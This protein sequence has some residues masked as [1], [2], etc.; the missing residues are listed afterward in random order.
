M[1][2]EW[3]NVRMSNTLFLHLSFQKMLL[4]RLD[5]MSEPQTVSEVVEQRM[6]GC[7]GKDVRSEE[8]I[9][10]WELYVELQFD[11]WIEKERNKIINEIK[12]EGFPKRFLDKVGLKI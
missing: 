5:S 12:K 9:E 7:K 4:E 10:S 1:N 2:N 3:K 11:E 6:K 8:N